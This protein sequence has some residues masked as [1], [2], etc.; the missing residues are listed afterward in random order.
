[1]TVENQ[2]LFCE[3]VKR[4]ALVDHPD[5]WLTGC[6][7]ELADMIERG[8][9]GEPPHSKSDWREVVPPEDGLIGP[10]G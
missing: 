7:C 4:S 10:V 5:A 9:R 6:L 1:M 3:A 8:E 2:K